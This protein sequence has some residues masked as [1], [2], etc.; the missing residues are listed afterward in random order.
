MKKKYSKNQLKVLER[1]MKNP[2][3]WEDADHTVSCKGPT[4]I[5]FPM[6]TLKKLQAIAQVT[7]KPI[8]RLVNEFVKPFVDA[9]FAILERLK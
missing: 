4:S 9:E 8:S 3:R 5:R 2:G 1:E 6:D 7:Q